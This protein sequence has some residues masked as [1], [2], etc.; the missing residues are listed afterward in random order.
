[1]KAQY[2]YAPPQEGEYE[3]NE[4]RE[5]VQLVND[6]AALLSE[7]GEAAFDEFR[8]PDSRWR[9]EENYIFVLDG[10]GNVLVHPDTRLEGRNEIDLK[11]INGKRIIRG[12]ITAATNIP[13]K[14][15]GWY[16]YQWPVPGG[17][18]PRWKSSFVKQAL[19]PA[20]ESYIVSSGI[21]NDRMEKAFV[22]DL[23][24]NA[25]AEIEKR[26]ESALKLFHDPT[27]PFLSK[28]TYIFALDMDGLELVNPALPNFEGRNVLDLVDAQGKYLNREMIELLRTQPSGWVTYMWPKPGENVPTQK[29]AFVH[30]AKL[31]DK[32]LV[33]GCGVYRTGAAPQVKAITKMN[34]FE[35]MTLV[36]KA[37]T[38]LEA[39]GEK[40]YPELREKGSAFFRDDTYFFVYDMDGTRAFHAAEPV[41]EGE[42]FL[43]SKD[44]LG[45]PFIR[46][47]INAAAGH[48]GEG[49]VHYLYPEPRNIFPIWKSSFVKRVIYPSGK[50]YAV[51]CG[52]YNMKMDKAFIEDMVKRAAALVEERGKEAF[53]EFR[54]KTGPFMFMDTYVFVQSPDG[55]E[56]VNPAQPS[57]EGRNLMELKDL[58]G[59]AVVR[60][61]IDAAMKDGSAWLEHYWYRPGDNTPALKQTYVQ[62]AKFDGE[63]FIVGSGLYPGY[64]G[65]R[66]DIQKLSWTAID[67]EHL[68]VLLSRQ[69]VFGENATLAR[70]YAKRGVTVPHMTHVNEE[71]SW[72]I[73]GSQK[74]TFD[75]REFVA[76]AGD[77]VVIPP[78]VAHSI[79]ILE[80][81]EFVD[82]F[83]PAREDWLQ[84]KDQY[85]RG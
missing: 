82:F 32:T 51:G 76:N 12:L 40:A 81:S 48:A 21:Y 29:D 4:T 59:K 1:M 35:L 18:L 74:F 39:K 54:D 79:T 69:T 6:A 43:K 77:V 3:F 8:K 73:S 61:E 50:Q 72:I 20:G 34:A 11:D 2:A 15:E 65:E 47:I 60:E 25:V 5:L 17:L 23:V 57:L 10:E 62:R 19:T 64:A 22:V 46:M 37:A 58:K 16:H 41:T 42:N 49:W 44:P 78:N 28:D 14:P 80:D 27:G 13:A 38:L 7:K 75:D 52:I 33:V 70:L 83:A 55:T 26:G 56:L 66:S 9:Q 68:S 53:A 31:G 30:R 63:T 71:Y 85:L 24:M 36:R 84:G 67:K 45:R